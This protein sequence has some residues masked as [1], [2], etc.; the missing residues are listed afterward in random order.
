M[1]EEEEDVPSVGPQRPNEKVLCQPPAQNFGPIF[2]NPLLI[3]FVL[4]STFSESAGYKDGAQ[5]N[6]NSSQRQ[7][8]STRMGWFWALLLVGSVAYVESGAP[9]FS[10]NAVEHIRAEF[11]TVRRTRK[12]FTKIEITA[13][14]GRMVEDPSDI[15]TNRVTVETKA[16]DLE[17]SPNLVK[18]LTSGIQAEETGQWWRT[19]QVCVEVC[20]S[21]L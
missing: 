3:F 1:E 17:F 4:T 10:S 18:S 15:D 2:V 16:G 13:Q 5:L 19:N 7:F 6:R 21:Y 8:F 14:P 11:K 12:D 9:T 20:P